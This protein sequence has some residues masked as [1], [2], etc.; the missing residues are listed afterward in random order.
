MWSRCRG[1]R[2]S[3]VRLLSFV[4]VCAQASPEG[5]PG[6]ERVRAYARDLDERDE[7]SLAEPPPA[8]GWRAFVRGTVAELARAG[9]PL[10]GTSLQISGELP[11]GT[12][13]SSSAAL[14]VALC[15][16]L[17]DLGSRAFPGRAKVVER[18][19][20]ARLCAR[21]ENEWVGAQSGLLDQLATLYGALRPR[22]AETFD[23]LDRALDAARG[24]QVTLLDEVEQGVVAPRLVAKAPVVGRGLDNRLGIAAEEALRGALP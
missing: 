20:I 8:P 1:A 19:D 24:Q 17:A 15:L 3:T 21:V 16:A 4:T 18:T 22:E 9:F 13:L 23:V 6:D 14:E 10:V 5:L 11:P 7:F 12:G 2:A